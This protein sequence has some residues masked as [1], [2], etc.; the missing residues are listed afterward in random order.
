[1]RTLEEQ[2]DGRY[3]VVLEETNHEPFRGWRLFNIQYTEE[4]GFTGSI[5]LPP[6]VDEKI[7]EERLR[8]LLSCEVREC[9]V[10]GEKRAVWVVSSGL[11]AV[12]HAKCYECLRRGAEPFGMFVMTYDVCGYDMADWFW[13]GVTFFEGGYA[14]I[15]EL[16]EKMDEAAAD[17]R[18]RM[19]KDADAQRQADHEREVD[20]EAR[21]G[22]EDG[23][24]TD[25]PA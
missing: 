15:S 25:F 16:K 7:V 11:G 3:K 24:Y 17:L 6:G 10:C 19:A 22:N 12:S 9:E 14:E 21:E 2:F 20:L 4:G 23:H 18:E 5:W 8:N 13:Q 1:M